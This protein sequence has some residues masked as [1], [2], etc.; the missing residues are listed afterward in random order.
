MSHGT[1]LCFRRCKSH[2]RSTRLL[3]LKA[4]ECKQNLELMQKNSPTFGSC[5]AKVTV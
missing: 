1:L 4:Q 2:I 3:I 5:A